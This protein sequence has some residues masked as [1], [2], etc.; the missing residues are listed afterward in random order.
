MV[1][2]LIKA[3]LEILVSSVLNIFIDLVSSALDIFYY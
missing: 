1:G 2:L 3:L